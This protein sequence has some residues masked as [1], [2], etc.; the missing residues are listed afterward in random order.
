MVAGGGDVNPV[1]LRDDAKK[2][3]FIEKIGACGVPVFLPYG[4]SDATYRGEENSA[5]P[6]MEGSEG[7]EPT[8]ARLDDEKD[9]VLSREQFLLLERAS[10]AK[11]YTEEFDGNKQLVWLYSEKHG[12]GFRFNPQCRLRGRI[13]GSSFVP[14]K[15]AREALAPVRNLQGS[16]S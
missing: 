4:K 15:K 2:I 6:L 12:G 3:A 14:P 16:G 7:H 10:S 13:S 11:L 9:L 8:V 1:T 5:F